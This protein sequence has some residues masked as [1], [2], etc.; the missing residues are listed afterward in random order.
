MVP[1]KSSAWLIALIAAAAIGLASCASDEPDRMR[2]LTDEEQA[3]I[4]KRAE[5]D[6]EHLD[7]N[8]EREQAR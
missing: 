7:E 5:R 3:A 4:E 8:I 6:Q 2:P 1:A